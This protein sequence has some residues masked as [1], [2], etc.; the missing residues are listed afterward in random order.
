MLT[1][2]AVGGQGITSGFRDVSGLS[3]R[4]ELAC[5]P[6]YTQYEQLL[7]GW[8]LERKDQ[9]DKSLAATVENGRYCN[10]SSPWRDYVRD[11]YMWLVQ[12][13]PPWKRQLE[14][15]ARRYGMTQYAFESGKLFVPGPAGGKL[16][17][18]VYCMPLSPS[19]EPRTTKQVM[20]TDDAIFAPHK[21]GLLQLVLL[22]GHADIPLPWNELTEV[23]T[24]SKGLV[25]AA[26]LTV[27]VED[28]KSS[29]SG[30]DLGLRVKEHPNTSVVRVATAEEFTSSTL[31]SNRPEPQYYDEL[32]IGKE[33][34]Y[35]RY[36]VVR[37][38]RFIYAACG[39]LTELKS[40][41]QILPSMLSVQ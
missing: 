8:C 21:T 35:G 11:T 22:I 16:L 31:C 19:E 32:R 10:E 6:G 4:L 14:Q 36:I 20:F 1:C 40:A 26:E 39:S 12:L 17:P 7:H 25:S 27:I 37:K 23:D 28:P 2:T 18:Q 24:W 33:V 13:Y 34:A 41:L 3:W 29:T 30:T 9:L 38:D 15:G 5:R